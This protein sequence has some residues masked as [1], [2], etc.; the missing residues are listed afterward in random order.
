METGSDDS[1]ADFNNDGLA[2]M[3][4]GRLPVRSSDDAAA[5][6]SKILAYERSSESE[7]VLL[8][9]DIG[10]TYDFEDASARLR[11]L[12]PPDVR[13]ESIDR[14]R[15]DAAEAKAIRNIFTG[16]S[17]TLGEATVKAKA[18]VG[19]L[20]VRRTWILFGDPSARIK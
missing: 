18:A 13:V 1:L 5:M 19:D 8:V 10:D 14:G 15:I 9:S 20:D 2:E 16:R 12:I 3:A 6:V 17:T 11:A 4:I 7:G